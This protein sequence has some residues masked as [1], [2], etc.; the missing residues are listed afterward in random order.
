MSRVCGQLYYLFLSIEMKMLLKQCTQFHIGLGL[1]P[2][3][4]SLGMS[5]LTIQKSIQCAMLLEKLYKRL[6]REGMFL[7]QCIYYTPE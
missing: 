3:R 6:E 5:L 4:G 2:V 1:S 7:N